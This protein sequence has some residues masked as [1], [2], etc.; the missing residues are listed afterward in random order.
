MEIN[1]YKGI[2]ISKPIGL[3][4]AYIT[5]SYTVKLCRET[6]IILCS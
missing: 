1:L 6:G 4:Y 3:Q 5:I 2:M